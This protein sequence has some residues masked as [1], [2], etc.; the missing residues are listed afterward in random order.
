MDGGNSVSSDVGTKALNYRS[1]GHHV[2]SD[3]NTP[4]VY[5]IGPS[6]PVYTRR[7]RLSNLQYANAVFSY[8]V[9]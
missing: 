7:K 9:L 3:F 8:Y 6:S 4:S 1:C 5:L 2:P